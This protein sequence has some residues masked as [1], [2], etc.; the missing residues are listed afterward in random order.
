M[1]FNRRQDEEELDIRIIVQGVV[2]DQVVYTCE[3]ECPRLVPQRAEPI[4][5]VDVVEIEALEENSDDTQSL[6]SYVSALSLITNE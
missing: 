6:N 4:N 3:T 5:Q 2:R 1:R